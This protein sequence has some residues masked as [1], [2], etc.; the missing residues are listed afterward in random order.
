LDPDSDPDFFTQSGTWIPD[1]GVK[2]APDPDP[3]HCKILHNFWRNY[4]ERSSGGELRA[5]G[6]GHLQDPGQ[7]PLQGLQ[8]GQLADQLFHG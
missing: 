7:D 5:G 6:A 8:Q 3:Q 4:L 1:P 2:K